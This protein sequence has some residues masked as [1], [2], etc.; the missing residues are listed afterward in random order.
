MQYEKEK[1]L[2]I[3]KPGSVCAL[4]GE[5]LVGE[6]KHLSVLKPNHQAADGAAKSGE[7]PP[8]EAKN[9]ESEEPEFI[10]TDYHR[11]CWKK[12][13]KAD[14]LSFWLAKRPAPPETPKMTRQERNTRLL[15]LFGALMKTD[16]PIDE[17]AKFVLS[18]LL[19]RYRA[20]TLAP[21][22]IDEDGRKWINFEIL[23]T[24]DKFEIPDIRLSDEQA[25][26]TLG[27]INEYL[28][29]GGR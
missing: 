28:N 16:D 4:C 8:G 26:E 2:S 18:H 11:E 27:R 29:R 10:R 15:A 24:E 1:L 23:Q 17:P 12:V 22:R 6:P 13:R 19:M 5:S 9:A 3:T 25:A 20:L 14:Y 21:S 7:T